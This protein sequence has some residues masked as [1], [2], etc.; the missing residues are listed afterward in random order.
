MIHCNHQRGQPSFNPRTPCGVRH[1]PA[2][3]ATFLHE[4]SIHALLAECD[5][6]RRAFNL[7]PIVSI[8]ALLAE[9]DS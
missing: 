3:M 1:D 7:A 8:H 4:V 9:C 5:T 6:A 2:D